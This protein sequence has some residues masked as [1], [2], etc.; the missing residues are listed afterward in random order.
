MQP[1]VGEIVT[2]EDYGLLTLLEIWDVNVEKMNSGKCDAII[3]DAF[4]VTKGVLEDCDGLHNA[5]DL[6]FA[7]TNIYHVMRGNGI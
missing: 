1:F 6:G 3:E 7:P 2:Q 5:K 4:F